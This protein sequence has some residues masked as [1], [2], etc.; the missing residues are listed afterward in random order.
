MSGYVIRFSISTYSIK[1]KFRIK[2]LHWEQNWFHG[3]PTG[4][5]ESQKRVKAMQE[6]KH[7]T[8]ISYNKRSFHY[9]QR[10]MKPIRFAAMI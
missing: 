7:K 6:E 8:W 10:D 1:K 9:I 4:R 5:A 2:G 3:S